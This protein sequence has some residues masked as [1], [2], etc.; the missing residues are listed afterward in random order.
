[1]K[2]QKTIYAAFVI[3]ILIVIS[4]FFS[5]TQSDRKVINPSPT[6]SSSTSLLGRSG[7]D[8]LYPNSSLTPGDVFPNATSQDVCVSGYSSSVRNVP[9][10]EK[11]QVYQEYST[12]YPQPQGSYEVDHF[13]SLELGGSNDIKNLW[14]EPAEPRPGFHEKDKVENYLHDQVCS[15][16][17]TLV[18][19]QQEIKTD[20]Y[21]VYLK[22]S[23]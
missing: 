8:R 14:P 6:S 9:I 13:I 16:K 1:M 15:G 20:W 22:I 23:K 4:I 10:S 18:Q 12:A 17:E 19:A 11:K 2:T 3:S 5:K 7:E 21:T